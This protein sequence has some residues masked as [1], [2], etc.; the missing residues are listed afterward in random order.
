ME[1]LEIYP[2]FLKNYVRDTNVIKAGTNPNVE[3]K[4]LLLPCFYTDSEKQGKIKNAD[5]KKWDRVLEKLSKPLQSY[6]EFKVIY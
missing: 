4:C 2:T 3:Q 1:E 6:E 5:P